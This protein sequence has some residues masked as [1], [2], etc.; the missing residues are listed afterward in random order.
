[1]KLDFWKYE[2]GYLEISNWISGN[3]KISR[4]TFSLTCNSSGLNFP[5]PWPSCRPATHCVGKVYYC[6]L[7][8][9][10]HWE[11]PARLPD[12]EDL[13]HLPVPRR[14]APVLSTVTYACKYVRICITIIAIHSQPLLFFAL[15]F[16]FA[17]P[18][19]PDG[20]PILKDFKLNY[21]RGDPSR[22]VL[23]GCSPDGHYRWQI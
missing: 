21:S 16:I 23:A 10:N 6:Q 20:T 14:D 8:D 22:A 12:S 19:I 3:I 2:T 5:K 7:Q 11:G 4:R 13:L 18:P 9:P 15:S 1:M 17:C